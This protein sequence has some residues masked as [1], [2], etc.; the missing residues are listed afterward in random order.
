[1]I[2]FW[3]AFLSVVSPGD[4]ITKSVND[5]EVDG[6][7]MLMPAFPWLLATGM[8]MTLHPHPHPFLP[9]LL[10]F[11]PTPHHHKSTSS[12]EPSHSIA[13]HLASDPCS[14]VVGF[15]S[16][17]LWKHW[18]YGL[19]RYT[20]FYMATALGVGYLTY[21]R[22]SRII[23][24]A[25]ENVSLSLSLTGQYSWWILWNL[26]IIYNIK[27]LCTNNN[28]GDDINNNNNN[29][30]SISNNINIIAIYKM[31]YDGG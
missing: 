8:M 16:S 27:Q 1:M 24:F 25:D 13:G 9:T 10:F 21:H 30:Y 26:F 14:H 7:H 23:M 12:C 22:V 5:C 19:W 20:C 2:H 28:E 4:L 6:W 18:H 29:K 3:W 15:P 17:W 31:Q 11:S